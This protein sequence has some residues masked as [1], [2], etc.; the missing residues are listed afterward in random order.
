FDLHMP[1]TVGAGTLTVRAN[2]NDLQTWSEADQADFA[3]YTRVTLAVPANM[4][5]TIEFESSGDFEFRVDDICF[6]PVPP[7]NAEACPSGAF[8]LIRY[9]TFEPEKAT[10]ADALAANAEV[11]AAWDGDVDK[12]ITT[13]DPGSGGN[14]GSSGFAHF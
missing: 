10:C 14:L 4:A 2:G 8:T 9:G 5:H 7:P 6:V 1:S 3:A 11:V 12:L 13:C